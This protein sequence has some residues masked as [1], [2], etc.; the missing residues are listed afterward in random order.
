MMKTFRIPFAELQLDPETILQ[1]M[2]YTET[3]PAPPFVIE[4]MMEIFSMVREKTEASCAY[5][6]YEGKAGKT[7]VDLGDIQLDTG[8]TIASLLTNSGQFAVFAAT[9]GTAFGQLIHEAEQE[10]DILKSYMLDITGSCIAEKAGDYLE[11]QLESEPGNISHTNRFSPGYCNW[12]LVEQR[13]IFGLLGGNPCGISLTEVCLMF[14]VKSISGI[15]GIGE[16]V[17]RKL[18]AC[19][20]CDLTTCYKRKNLKTNKI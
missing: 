5:R 17:S 19:H 2:G 20:I 18:Y 8:R 15:I 6:L 11:R 9:A 13:K 3:Q 1:E 12:A 16:N 14:P 7:G 10:G 4:M